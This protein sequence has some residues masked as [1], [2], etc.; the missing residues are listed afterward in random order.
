MAGG[1]P[2][3]GLAGLG[4]L[5]GLAGCIYYMGGWYL[6]DVG[7]WFHGHESDLVLGLPLNLH[8]L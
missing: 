7:S 3:G 6:M 8:V 4:W 1:W 2:A 5:A